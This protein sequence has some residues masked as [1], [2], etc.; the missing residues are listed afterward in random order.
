MTSRRKPGEE[1]RR[2]TR[3]LV[4]HLL[5][6]RRE[7]WV[8][9][10]R[11]AGVEPYADKTPEVERLPE[12]VE[13]LVD[14]V[15]T[16]HFGLYGRIVEG[17]ERREAVLELAREIYPRLTATTDTVVAF[18]DR[19]ENERPQTLD[20]E[21]AGELSRLGEALATRTELEDRLIDALLTPP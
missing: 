12:L 11:V 16:G 17:E 18:N 14:Y 15:A 5:S 6:E 21:L 13:I 19:Y 4:D 3:E 8:L 10:S 20:D 7:M 1:R 2:R 9:Y